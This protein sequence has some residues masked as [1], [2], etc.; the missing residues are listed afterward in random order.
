VG[1]VVVA[2]VLATVFVWAAC[3]LAKRIDKEME[4][5]RKKKM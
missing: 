2:S 1:V 5:E 4:D 3:D